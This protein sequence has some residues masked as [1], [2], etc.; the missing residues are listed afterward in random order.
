MAGSNA[1]KVRAKRKQAR[2]TK[3]QHTLSMIVVTTVAMMIILVVGV[4]A[5]GLQEK[6]EL[7]EAESQSIEEQIAKEEDRAL[8]IEE[9]GKEVQ[10]KKFYEDFARDKLGLIYPNEKVFK[11]QD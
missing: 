8:E 3:H 11:K 4:G 10:T 9:Y 5:K 7:L 2:K 1:T 6:K